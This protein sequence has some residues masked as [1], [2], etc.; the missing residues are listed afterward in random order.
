MLLQKVGCEENFKDVFEEAMR[1]TTKRYKRSIKYW[2]WTGLNRTVWIDIN[3]LRGCNWGQAGLKLMEDERCIPF[4]KSRANSRNILLLF[5]PWRRGNILLYYTCGLLQLTFHYSQWEINHLVTTWGDGEL[6]GG[7]VAV[8]AFV[9]YLTQ[10]CQTRL[11]FIVC[12][13]R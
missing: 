9:T 10:A 12:P 13:R 7:E 1:K 8:C 11:R 6:H 2:T 3:I 5:Y 4:S